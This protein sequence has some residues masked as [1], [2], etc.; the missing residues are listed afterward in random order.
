MGRQFIHPKRVIPG[1]V[2]PV[3]P[4]VPVMSML[5]FVFIFGW[6]KVAETMLNPMGEDDELVY[7][8]DSKRSSVIW[9]QTTFWIAI[10]KLG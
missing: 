4:I 8:T 10:C 6:T 3:D 9:R 2:Q 5:E 1:F 7:M